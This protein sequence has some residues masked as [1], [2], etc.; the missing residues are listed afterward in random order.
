MSGRPGGATRVDYDCTTC[1]ACCR[2]PDENVREGYV[3]YLE[4]R[5]TKLLQKKDLAKKLVVYDPD[6]A[7]HLRL[8]PSGRCAA[9]QGRIGERVRCTIYT[10]R[11]KGC[12]LL[13][14][15]DARCLL[16]RKERGIDP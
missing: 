8:D 16:A 11:P 7:P 14:P 12:R 13:E 10:L 9:L 5:D 1:G 15:G 3:W 4:V 6:G 2:N